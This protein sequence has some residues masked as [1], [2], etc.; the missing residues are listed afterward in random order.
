M[1]D[2]VH[3]L[4]ATGRGLEA[5][6][7]SAFDVAVGER[8]KVR[9]T[10]LGIT[11]EALSAE[12]GVSWQQL[13]KYEAGT[14]RISAARLAQIA[15]ALRTDVRWFLRQD[16][17]LGASPFAEAAAP[18]VGTPVSAAEIAEVLSIFASLPDAANRRRMIELMRLAA[19]MPAAK[20]AV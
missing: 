2:D 20:S 15:T 12:L 19:S 6:R 5:K 18:P 1:P 11:Q 3:K 13:Q 8:L 17:G 4:G 14:N 9:R 16:T 7:A 10:M